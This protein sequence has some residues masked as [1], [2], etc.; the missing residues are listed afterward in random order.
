MRHRSSGRR[1]LAVA[2]AFVALAAASPAWS[3]EES[4]LPAAEA[5][6]ASDSAGVS[7]PLPVAEPAPAGP[8][9]EDLP[10]LDLAGDSPDFV[11]GAADVVKVLVWRNPE[12]SAEV[13]VRPDGR[14][15][16]PLLGD[17]QAAGLTT[18]ELRDRIAAG[19]SA[20]LTAPDVTVSVSQV[21][22]KV[23]FLVGEVQRPS[24]IPLNRRMRVLDAIAMAGGFTP[25]A[26]KGDIKILRPRP[27]GTVEEY[28]FN[29]GRFV[30]GKAPESNLVLEAGDTIVV[31]D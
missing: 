28:E 6:D 7:E 17:V 12:L 13:P 30:K 20:Y 9:A 16:V 14:I 31:P 1:A 27:D 11:I 3:Q 26:D 8:S 10:A 29:Y 2:C 25:F 21:N 22:S 19:L 24:A 23:V 5:P 15:T 18:A 4:G